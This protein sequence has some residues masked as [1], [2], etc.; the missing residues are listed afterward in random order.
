MAVS[1]C[2]D[3]LF[4]TIRRLPADRKFY[5]CDSINETTDYGFTLN[6]K[7][8]NVAIYVS[9]EYFW[10]VNENRHWDGKPKI[11][12][13]SICIAKTYNSLESISIV[14]DS[15]KSSKYCSGPFF[16]LTNNSKDTLYGNYSPGYFWGTRGYHM[17]L[18]YFVYTPLS[19]TLYI[20][21]KGKII[22]L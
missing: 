22:N 3:R 17:F 20:L 8:I 9:Y 21:S 4:Q 18:E 13:G 6:N 19:F 10:T 7:E 5:Y 11:P 1:E 12:M 16:R 15:T 14:L 2:E